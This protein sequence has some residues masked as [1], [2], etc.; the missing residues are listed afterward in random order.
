V[1]AK[2]LSKKLSYILRHNPGD[3]GLVLDAGGW[4]GVAPLLASLAKPE[5]K[6]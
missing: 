4:V 1:N 2:A 5:A 6:P 3:A